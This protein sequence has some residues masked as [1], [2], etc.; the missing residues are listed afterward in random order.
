MALRLRGTQN[1]LSWNERSVK[2]FWGCMCEA[3]KWRN[4]MVLGVG[5]DWW[6]NQQVPWG[7]GHWEQDP[8]IC[9]ENERPW[10]SLLPPASAS[11]LTITP[12]CELEVSRELVC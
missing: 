3:E 8:G 2:C 6:P 11:L 10:A 4:K 12:T 7:A 1:L 9:V 5:V